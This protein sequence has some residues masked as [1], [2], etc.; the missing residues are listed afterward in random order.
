[1]DYFQFFMS[2]EDGLLLLQ[3]IWKHKPSLSSGADRVSGKLT[4]QHFQLHH[5][6]FCL[7]GLKHEGDRRPNQEEA[8]RRGEIWGKGCS[9]NNVNFLDFH[10]HSVGLDMRCRGSPK[11]PQWLGIIVFKGG[12][13][14]FVSLSLSDK[15]VMSDDY[16]VMKCIIRYSHPDKKRSVSCHYQKQSVEL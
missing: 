13:C 3:W 11:L 7:T 1:M 10:L 4:H 16:I 6:T 5:H 2:Q 14:E 15:A 8:K 12:R 9:S